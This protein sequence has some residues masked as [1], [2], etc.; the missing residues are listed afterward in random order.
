MDWRVIAAKGL[1]ILGAGIFLI[2]V[3]MVFGP[4]ATQNPQ[5]QKWITVIIGAVIA[6]LGA[7]EVGSAWY[8][9]RIEEEEERQRMNAKARR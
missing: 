9:K 6:L 3:S 2:G 1:V 7:G 8:L 4:E 5:V